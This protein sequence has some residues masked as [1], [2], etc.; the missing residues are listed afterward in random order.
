MRRSITVVLISLLILT[1]GL[2]AYAAAPRRLPREETLYEAGQQWGPPTNYNPFVTTAAWPILQDLTVYETLFGYNL[3][4]GKL[5]PILGKSYEWVDEYTLRI[6]LQPGT[7]WQDGK[8]LTAEDVVYTFEL[9]KKY[10]VSF[11]PLWNHLTKA[12]AV[13]DRTIEL[14]LNPDNAHKAMVETYIGTIRIVPKHIWTE[15]EKTDGTVTKATNMEPVGSGP[16]KVIHGDPQQIIIERDD[17]YWGIPIYGKPGPRY[18]VHPIFKSNDAGNLAFERGQVD[19]SQQFVPE[20]WKMWEE[21]GLPVGTWY[22]NEPYYVPASIPTLFMNTQKYPLS[23]PAVRRAIAYAIDYAKIAE[24][25]MSRYSEPAKSSLLIPGVPSEAKYFSEEDVKKYGWEYNPQKAVEILEKELGAKKGS[26][27]IY[28]LPDGTRLGTFYAECPYG[29]T[30]WMTSLEVVA[31][32]CRAIGIDV[33]TKFP[34]QPVWADHRDS[35]NFDL[36]MNTP[37]GEQSP[38]QPWVRIRDVMDSRGVPA[39]GKGTAYRNWGRYHN[40]KVAGLLDK[41]ATTTDEA[42]LKEVYQEL[43]RIFMQDVPAIPLEYRPWEFFEY[44]ET[45]W[46]GFPNEDNPVAPPQFDF[47]GIRVLFNLKPVKK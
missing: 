16:Y 11:S 3:V 28:V 23:L 26:D 20:I 25:A 39:V 44:N 31:Q 47:A 37:A 17:N 9:G 2:T 33:Q 15:I 8:P 21:K 45:Y 41:A 34:D 10:A 6:E 40:D 24:T 14:T 38:A 5:E 12:V 46:T 1:T 43:N 7:R 19:L 13:D 4:A 27:G 35:G 30:D 22:K 36:L 32:S 29:W 42:V 18:I